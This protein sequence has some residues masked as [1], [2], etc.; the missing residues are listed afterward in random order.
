MVVAAEIPCGIGSTFYNILS[1]RYLFEILLFTLQ[2]HCKFCLKFVQ[3]GL[4]F[5]Q[6]V[7][8][9]QN[10]PNGKPKNERSVTCKA[11]KIFKAKGLFP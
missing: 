1:L 10:K 7:H 11:F 8:L 2:I 3:E 9:K 6:T 5:N 4:N